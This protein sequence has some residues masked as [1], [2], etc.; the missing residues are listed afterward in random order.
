MKTKKGARVK[1]SRSSKRTILHCP[2]CRKFNQIISVFTEAIEITIKS[3]VIIKIG[4]AC[5]GYVRG[6]DTSK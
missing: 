6:Y 1:K 5:C 3:E 4:Y 2:K